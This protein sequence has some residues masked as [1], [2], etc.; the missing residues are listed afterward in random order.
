MTK[1]EKAKK[2]P[3]TTPQPMAA[4]NV[5]NGSKSSILVSSSVLYTV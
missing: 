2:T 4:I 3:A 1:A 5:S